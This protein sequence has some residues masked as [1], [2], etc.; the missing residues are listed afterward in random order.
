VLGCRIATTLGGQSGGSFG[1]NMLIGRVRGAVERTFSILKRRY[2]FARMRYRGLK[3]N[4][5]HLD[6][7]V[8][9]HNLRTAAALAA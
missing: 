2:G 6:L 1:R 5:F 4:A 8:I 9:A 7:G 3:A